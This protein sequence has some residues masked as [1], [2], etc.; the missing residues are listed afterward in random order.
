M[1]PVATQA[2]S[3]DDASDVAFEDEEDFAKK[4]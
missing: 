1:Q 3:D 4:W 2:P